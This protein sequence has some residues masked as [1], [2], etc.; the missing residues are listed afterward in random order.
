MNAFVAW[1]GAFAGTVALEAIVLSLALRRDASILALAV[2]AATHP[3]LWLAVANGA[4]LAA[5]E[6]VATLVEAALLAFAAPARPGRALGAACAANA[7][8]LA[9]GWLGPAGGWR[10]LAT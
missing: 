4:G 5:S 1:A 6:F 7:L 9:V 2:N 3:A 10:S 8:S